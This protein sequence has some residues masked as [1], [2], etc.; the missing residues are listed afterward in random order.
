M[1]WIQIDEKRA[2][3]QCS[4]FN[5]LLFI[6]NIQIETIGGNASKLNTIIEH[7]NRDLH[8]KTRIAMGLQK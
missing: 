8:T 1:Y 6:N 2:L 3:T 5:K 7:P 4:E